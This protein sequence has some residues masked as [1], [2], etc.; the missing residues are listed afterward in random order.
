VGHG[1]GS[2]ERW[3]ITYS[4]LITLL[5]VFFV[6]M[7]SIS[8]ADKDKYLLLKSSLQR[9]FK[10]EAEAQTSLVAKDGGAALLDAPRPQPADIRLE[11][12]NPG[13]HAIAPLDASGTA[14]EGDRAADSQ[15]LDALRQAIVPM[16]EAS[17]ALDSVNVF[18]TDEGVVISISGSLL[19][20]SGKAELKPDGTSF[21]NIIAD[22]TRDWPNR[23]RVEG[24]TDNVPIDTSLYPSNWELSAARSVVVAR[25]LTEQDG[26]NSGRV[27]AAAYGEFRPVANNTTRE[28]RSRN[29]RVDILVL[30]AGLAGAT[31]SKERGGP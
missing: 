11:S 29:R 6:V 17:G 25:F 31:T 13:N 20:D 12:S 10:G 24:H 16:A 1:G 28:G 21:L 4:D 7:Y 22:T 15:K 14:T 9:A 8:E 27:G 18:Q 19:F 5:M 23:L 2:S 30:D 3:L 26:L